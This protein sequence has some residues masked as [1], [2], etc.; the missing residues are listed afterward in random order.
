MKLETLKKKIA[1][2]GVDTVWVVFPDVMG[3]LL[4]KRATG[5]YFLEHVVEHGTHACN[6]LLVVN[7]EMDPL[8]GFALANWEKGFGD[9]AMVPDL[10]TLRLLPWQAGSAMVLCDLHHH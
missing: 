1:S 6:Y 7:M 10:G 5:R 8:D 2:G 9:F 4:G 3:R